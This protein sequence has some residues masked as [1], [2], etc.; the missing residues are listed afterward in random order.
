MQSSIDLVLQQAQTHVSL[1][2]AHKSDP[3]NQRPQVLVELQ[4]LQTLP[5]AQ[6]HCG[7]HSSYNSVSTTASI[8]KK[9]SRLHFCFASGIKVPCAVTCGQQRTQVSFA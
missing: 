8:G 6:M 9:T 7:A 2:T 5:T 3:C 1:L 4:L